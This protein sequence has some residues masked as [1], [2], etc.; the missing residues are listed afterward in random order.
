MANMTLLHSDP[1][2]MAHALRLAR[3]GM[4]TTDPNPRVGCVIVRE[5]EIVGEGW[6]EVAG[7]PH[8]EIH[9]LKMAKDKAKGATCYVT[10]EP[11]CYHGRT[12]P[13]TDAL[14]KAGITRVVVAVTDPN[15]LVS[16]KGMEQLSKAGVL[17]DIGTLSSE[18]EYL[19]LGFLMRMR[20]QRPYIRCKMAMSLD[21]RTAMASGESQ[22]I[23]SKDARTDVQALRARSS[24]ILTGAGTVLA[25]N[26]LLTVRLEELPTHLPK[27]T[28]I[29][30][31]LRVIVDSHLSTPPSAR[32]LSLPGKTVI[33]T[34]SQNTTI[35]TML[36][37]AGAQVIY[38]PS[39][40]GQIDLN[41]MCQKLAKD[42]EVNELLM[43]TGA[44]LAGCMLRAQLIDEIILYMAPLLMGNRARG[45]F[46]LPH[47]DSLKQRIP[48][49][50]SEIRAIGP[51][52]RIT[53]HPLYK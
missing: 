30:Q 11:C 38:M 7:G 1:Y 27:P 5:G 9:A 36:E 46:N 47:L 29:R 24:A 3:R 20:H 19:N 22:W 10:L 42:H 12:P 25:D 52:W 17:V 45:L 50:I 28:V 15:P 40:D 23:T 16:G 53:I 2:Y 39:R 34:A 31:P 26:P 32:L 14:I 44:T 43:E 18:A 4:W 37:K 51:D 13:C 8:A 6:H 21:G 33:F 41:S 49:E 48:L 35:K